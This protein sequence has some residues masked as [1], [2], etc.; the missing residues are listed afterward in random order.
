MALIKKAFFKPFAI[1]LNFVF[2]LGPAEMPGI[3][4][5]SGSFLK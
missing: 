3:I 5:I 2:P 1:G 4:L